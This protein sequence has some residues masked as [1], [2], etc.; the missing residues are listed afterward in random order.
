MN[1]SAQDFIDLNDNFLNIVAS[2]MIPPGIRPRRSSS[3]DSG[4]GTS[5]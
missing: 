4:E 1:K 2:S 3:K 5:L